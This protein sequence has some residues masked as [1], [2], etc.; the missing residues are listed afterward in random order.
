MYG[1]V[2]YRSMSR[3]D[4]QTKSDLLAFTDWLEGGASWAE[5]ESGLVP[6]GSR[7]SLPRRKRRRR[8]RC[9]CYYYHLLLPENDGSVPTG[10]KESIYLGLFSL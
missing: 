2:S 4:K 9:H 10:G 6:R 1:T 7:K 3:G 8:R 5:L